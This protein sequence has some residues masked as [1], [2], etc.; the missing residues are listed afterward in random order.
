MIRALIVDD[1]VLARDLVRN[2]LR[3]EE[4]VEIIGECDNGRDA[5]ALIRKLQ[6]DLLFLDVQM[7]GLSGIDVGKRLEVVK[8]PYIVYVTAYDR[9]AM[10][11]FDVQALDYL[12]KPLRAER[13]SA[14][15]QRARRSLQRDGHAVGDGHLQVREGRRLF[16]IPWSEIL[17]LESANQYVRVHTEGREH[18]LARSL[19]SLEKILPQDRFV[20]IHRS[21]LVNLEFVEQVVGLGNGTHEVILLNGQRLTLSRSRRAALHRLLARI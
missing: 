20:R 5:L 8:S 1:E 9:Y 4:D 14:A 15:V 13:F 2:L 21:A 16:A 19:A 12:L 6:P 7:P 17:Y 10:E 3:R 18:L 11:A